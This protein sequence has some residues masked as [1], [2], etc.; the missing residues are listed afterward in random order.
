MADETPEPTV[1]I[2]LVTEGVTDQAVLESIV[3]GALHPI[4]IEFRRLQPVLDATAS[5]ASDIPGGWSGVVMYCELN[6]LSDALQFVDYVIVQIDSDTCED[7]P[8]RIKKHGVDGKLE[9]ER[10]VAE[11]KE[12]LRGKVPEEAAGYT[13]PAVAFAVAVES[14]ECWILPLHTPNA[15]SAVYQSCLRHLNTAIS[16]K[17]QRG[18]NPDDKLMSYYDELTREYRKPRELTRRLSAN[19]S[20]SIFVEEIRTLAGR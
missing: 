20:L 15:R 4:S 19:V 3:C 6:R 9:P 11:L 1:V 16:R 12:A 17:N 7:Q 13:L 5:A 2:G 18:I 8:F 14:I 10:I